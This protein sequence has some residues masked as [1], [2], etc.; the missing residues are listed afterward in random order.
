M[1]FTILPTLDYGVI[2]KEISRFLREE[3][4]KRNKTTAVLGVSGGVDSSIAAFL[5]EKAG[6]DLKKVFMPYGS[7]SEH[8]QGDFLKID[9]T[10]PVDLLAGS[11]ADKISKG[12]IMTRVR[13]IVLYDLARKLKGLVVGTENLSEYY[14]GYFTLYGDQACD[15]NPIGSLWKTQVVELAKYLGLPVREPSAE[16]WRGQTDEKEL[17]FSYEDA[18][19]ILYLYCV[20]KMEPKMIAKDFD[21][22]PD[23]VYRVVERVKNTGYKREEI[24][25]YGKP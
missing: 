7:L 11:K 21:F 9:I 1:P 12:N 15:I 8:P 10:R 6:L 4:K 19:P 17:G 16:L 24:P 25:K 18:D 20:K 5:C 3:F 13:M 23:L 22:S 2:A 14:L